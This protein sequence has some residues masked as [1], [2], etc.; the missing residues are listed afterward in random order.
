VIDAAALARLPIFA[1]LSPREL[2]ILRGVVRERTLRPGQ[3]LFRR[4]DPGT[5]FFVVVTGRVGVWRDFAGAQAERIVVLGPGAMLGEMSLIDGQ[6]RSAEVRADDVP[7]TLA[8]L[9]RDDFDR[10]F[11]AGTPL[12]FK[13]LRH[14]SGQLVERFRNTMRRLHAAHE[15]VAEANRTERQHTAAA[16]ARFATK[17]LLGADVAADELDEVVVVRQP[18]KPRRP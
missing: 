7:V 8:E 5:A 1:A 6:R 2:E 15:Q 18:P 12:T 10:L 11:N 14:I 3:V 17:A 16:A 13:I 4:G 9:T